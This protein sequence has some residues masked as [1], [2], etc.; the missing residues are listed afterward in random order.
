M[1][2]IG[3]TVHVSSLLGDAPVRELLYHGFPVRLHFRL[4]LWS[5]RGWFDRQLAATEWD[6]VTRYDSFRERF[7]VVRVVADSAIPLGLFR[8]FGEMVGEVER[9]RNTPLAARRGM[10]EQYYNVVLTREALSVSDLDELQRWLRGDLSP[11]V[12]GKRNPGTALS[13]GART[14]LSRLLGGESRTLEEQ[15]ARFTPPA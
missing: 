3:P 8:T 12:R 14:L 1:L 11:A 13:R 15:S 5:T 7:E 6:L 4:E 9:A 2:V 10:G